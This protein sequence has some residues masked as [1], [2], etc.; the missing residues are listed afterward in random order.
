MAAVV[1]P[2]GLWTNWTEK[3]KAGGGLRMAAG[4]DN[5]ILSAANFSIMRVRTGVIDNLAKFVRCGGIVN[6]S[7][8]FNTKSGSEKNLHLAKLR[9]KVQRLVLFCTP[10]IHPHL[11]IILIIL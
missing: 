5:S 10:C 11:Y 7:F 8:K 4:V 3:D 6:D 2:A 1:E 9:A